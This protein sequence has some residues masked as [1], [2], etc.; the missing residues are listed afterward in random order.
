[1]SFTVQP[2]PFKNV[3]AIHLFSFNLHNLRIP[4][5]LKIKIKTDLE[6]N[7]APS[8]GVFSQLNRAA[9]TCEPFSFKTRFCS[10]TEFEHLSNTIHS[11]TIHFQGA[12]K[13]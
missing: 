2:Y 7:S 4:S 9:T 10:K 11:Q 13:I 12:G 1:M 6:A 3:E 5:F 8:K